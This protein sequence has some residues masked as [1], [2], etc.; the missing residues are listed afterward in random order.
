MTLE[1]EGLNTFFLFI[2]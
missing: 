1:I 2:V